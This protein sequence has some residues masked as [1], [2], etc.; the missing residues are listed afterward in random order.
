M[1]ILIKF[2][3][4]NRREKFFQVLDLYYNLLDDINKTEFLITID[5]DD[6]SMNNQL[7][8]D[9]LIQYK[10]LNFTVGT[11]ENKIHAVNRDIV[12]KNWDILL[13]ASDDM[14]P[15]IKGYDKIIRDKMSEFF[16]DTDGVLWFNDGNRKD[17][18]TLSILG[19]K[20]YQRFNYIYYHGYKSLWADN[21]FM[22]VAN[23]LNKQKFFDE[24]IIH[25]EHPDYGFG[26][27]DD[28]HSLNSINDSYDRNLF[29][30]RKN[31]NFDL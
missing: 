20:Y 14:I 30:S 31:R 3:T 29:I 7:T 19:L 25:H 27:R 4:R 24:V 9:K 15:Q 6:L 10:N 2:P 17:L 23:L 18:N 28:I 5:E 21:E 8:L 16:P 11:S 26:N 1:N 22:T 12:E 13:L